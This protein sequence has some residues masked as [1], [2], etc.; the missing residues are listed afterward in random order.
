MDGELMKDLRGKQL[1]ENGKNDSAAV[2][3]SALFRFKKAQRVCLV[4]LGFHIG[5]ESL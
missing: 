2:L 4:A 5:E 3:L 1:H